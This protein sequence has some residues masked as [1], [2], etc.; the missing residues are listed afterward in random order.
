LKR[1]NGLDFFTPAWGSVG[2]G[3][4]V[5]LFPDTLHEY[6][7]FERAALITYYKRGESVANEITMEALPDGNFL[8]WKEYYTGRMLPQMKKWYLGQP[9]DNSFEQYIKY[10]DL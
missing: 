9:E 7:T 4:N 1:I 10:T 6:I 3:Y 5:A 2:A 8:R